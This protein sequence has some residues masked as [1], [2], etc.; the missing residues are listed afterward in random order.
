MRKELWL[1][2][3]S[4]GP[5]KTKPIWASPAGIRGVDYAEQSQFARREPGP[6]RA[7]QT[8][9]AAGARW[10]GARGVEDQGQMCKTNPIWG[11]SFKCKVSSV[12]LG[13]FS[14]YYCD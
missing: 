9:F 8:Q 10:H 4:I 5:D 13:K 2:E 11:E 1:I 7:K 12:M 6:H 14:L 3:H